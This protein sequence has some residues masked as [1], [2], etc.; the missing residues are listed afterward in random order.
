MQ[1]ILSSTDNEMEGKREPKP[2]PKHTDDSS[3]KHDDQPRK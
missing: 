1:Q 2:E 3:R